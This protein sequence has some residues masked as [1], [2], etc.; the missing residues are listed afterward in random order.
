MLKLFLH[1]TILSTAGDALNL[2]VKNMF[3]LLV[4]RDPL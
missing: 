1:G 2:D 3:L 4:F